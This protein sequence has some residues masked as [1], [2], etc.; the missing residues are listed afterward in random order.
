M[1]FSTSSGV[2]RSEVPAASTQATTSEAAASGQ[3][4][5][6]VAAAAATTTSAPAGVEANADAPS[7]QES[8]FIPSDSLQ[9]ALGST[10]ITESNLLQF[11]GVIEHKSNELMTLNYLFTTPRKIGSAGSQPQAT[12]AAAAGEEKAGDVAASGTVAETKASEKKEG[13]LVMPLLGT[14][15][16]LLGP[17]P[18]A[19]L[20]NL[21]VVAPSIW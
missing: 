19:P 13:T 1:P 8:S 5:E 7:P 11:L 4:D 17:G 9:L 21:A 16:A 12:A 18:A 15:G 10:A 14:V 6:E 2:Q 3:T 20:G